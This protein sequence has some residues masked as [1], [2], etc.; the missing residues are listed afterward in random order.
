MSNVG[1]VVAISADAQGPRYDLV[2]SVGRSTQAKSGTAYKKI[3]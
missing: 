1:R 2:K 3:V